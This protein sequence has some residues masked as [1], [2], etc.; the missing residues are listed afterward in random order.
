MITKKENINLN[1]CIQN[2]HF[3]FYSGSILYGMNT[4][5]SDVDIR[6]WTIPPFE[7]LI[8][9]KNFE[10]AELDGDNKV[11]SLKRFLQLALKGDP[12]VTE[13]LFAPEDKILKCSESGKLILS[14][15]EYLISNAIF[16]R[17]MGY[18]TGEWRK[19]MAIKLV[20]FKW[21][22]E[23]HEVINDIRNLWHPD[24]ETMDNIIGSLEDIDE[25]EVVSSKSG[26][27]V[28]RKID[29]E[30]YGFCR[31]SAAHSIRLV[32]QVTELM[33]TGYMTFPHP[34]MGLLLDIKNGKYTKDELQEIYDSV[35]SEA[36]SARTKSI[37]P[38]KPDEKK[39]W[40]VYTKL[41]AEKIVNDCKFKQ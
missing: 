32:K 13:G 15:R 22:K 18:S 1:Y 14:H 35:V 41:V 10:C 9:V 27:G 21:K 29:V 31:K 19:A 17:I 4:I 24:K 6:S 39:V 28:K 11:Y 23:K 34:D 25:M 33:Q 5:D 36:E 26:L 2:P 16:G 30:K 20:P 38:N 40:E 3:S 8:G 37:L 12:S 7:Y